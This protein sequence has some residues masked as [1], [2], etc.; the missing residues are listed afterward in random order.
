MVRALV[1]RLARIREGARRSE[2]AGNS[3]PLDLRKR[4]RFD[5]LGQNAL[6]PAGAGR[7]LV[8]G[9]ERIKN[10]RFTA[11][12]RAC[13]EPL[14]GKNSANPK[15]STRNAVREACEAVE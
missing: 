14:R 2:C 9:C 11:K 6:Q 10:Q 15:R 1:R 13:E 8:S 5:Q 12:N 7:P 4:A 3:P